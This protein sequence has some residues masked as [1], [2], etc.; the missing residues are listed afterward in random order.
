[1]ALIND[2]SFSRELLAAGFSASE[3][4]FL[5][6]VRYMGDFSDALIQSKIDEIFDFRDNYNMTPAEVADALQE[7]QDDEFY[8]EDPG[9]EYY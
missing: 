5:L 4:E 9:V 7:A 2:R 1:M 6:L 8:D 3:V